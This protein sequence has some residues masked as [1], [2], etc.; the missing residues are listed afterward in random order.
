MALL[1][2]GV[3]DDLN[4]GC[5]GVDPSPRGLDDLARHPER[6]LEPEIRQLDPGVRT[7]P[8]PSFQTLQ[9]GRLIPGDVPKIHPGGLS[10]F[11]NVFTDMFQGGRRAVSACLGAVGASKVAGC[12][13]GAA[14]RR[15][16]AGPVKVSFSGGELGK[17]VSHTRGA[18]LTPVSSF[19][20]AP[21]H[22]APKHDIGW[23]TAGGKAVL[24]PWVVPRLRPATVDDSMQT[25][26]H[27]PPSPPR[28][29]R[30]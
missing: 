6:E 17:V 8:H 23:G 11:R 3:E 7:Y 14:G 29:N 26:A 15:D 20:H 1:S 28:W 18:R 21:C 24:A 19:F 10:T 4:D 30:T 2:P 13:Q 25:K 9:L 12:V 22:L 16:Q 5:R 27:Q